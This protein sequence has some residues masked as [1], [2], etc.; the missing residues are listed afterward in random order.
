MDGTFSER[1]RNTIEYEVQRRNRQNGEKT[2][3]PDIKANK[4]KKKKKS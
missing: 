1:K 3:D 2:N 4:K